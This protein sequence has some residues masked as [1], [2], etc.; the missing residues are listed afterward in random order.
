MSTLYFD[1]VY[2]YVGTAE[3]GKWLTFTSYYYTRLIKIIT[4]GQAIITVSLRGGYL[5]FCHHQPKTP[6]IIIIAICY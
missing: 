1:T 3:M 5:T 2:N 4:T 6:H